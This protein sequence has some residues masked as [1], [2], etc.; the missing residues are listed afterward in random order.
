MYC[1]LIVFHLKAPQAIVQELFRIC[2]FFNC[3]FDMS[4]AFVQDFLTLKVNLILF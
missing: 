2:N 1:S 4:L 3:Q